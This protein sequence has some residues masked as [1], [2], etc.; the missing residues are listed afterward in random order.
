V[1]GASGS[2]A[3]GKRTRGTIR[4]VARTQRIPRLMGLKGDKLY[5]FSR[6]TSTVY[7]VSPSQGLG[8]NGVFNYGS[9][10]SFNLANVIIL[11]QNAAPVVPNSDEFRALFEFWRIDK[12]VMTM[13]YSHVAGGGQSAAS[14][15]AQNPMLY[16]CPDYTDA[17]APANLGTM[18]QKTDCKCV[19]LVA[20]KPYKF[21]FTP[22]PATA[23]FQNG[24]FSGYSAD[25]RNSLWLST[26]YPAIENYGL[27]IWFQ[28]VD[29]TAA[30]SGNIL[31]DI[32]YHFSFKGV[33]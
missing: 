2:G 25:S 18:Q 14:N 3:G 30:F 13:H 9:G 32:E 21:A 22:K 31:A 16:L 7:T 23:V 15:A 6:K 1:S 27:K 10:L 12:I 29:L 17:A 24:A 4:A 26:Q 28:P 11:G 33:N 19:Q 20:G 5:R 8:I